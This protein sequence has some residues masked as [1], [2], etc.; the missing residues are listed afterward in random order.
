M[1]AFTRWFR[2]LGTRFADT[3]DIP[4]L[5]ALMAVM[6]ISLMVL[7]S[8]GNS[9][10]PLVFAQ[11]V[12][13]AA[14]LGAMFVFAQ[15]PPSKLR[16]WTPWLFAATL[17]LLL[18]VP[19]I[20]TGQSARSWIK[21]GKM[22]IQPSELLKLTVPMMVAWYLH[23]EPLPPGWKTLAVC[24]AIIGIP[25][26]L[27]VIQPAFGTG[28]LVAASGMFVIFLAGL[29]WWRI[30]LLAGLASGVAPLLWFFVL[31]DFQK[32]RI[33]NFLDPERDPQG[34]GWNIL[35]SQ[36]A[37]GSGGLLGKGWGHS[38]QAHLDFLPEHTTDFIFAV[39]SEEFGW[40]GVCTLLALYLFIVG[41]CLWIAANARETYARLLAGALAMTFFVYAM[42]NGGMVSGLL[43]VV[44]VPMPLL[45]YGGTSAVSLLAGFG[46]VMSVYAHRRFMGT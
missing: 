32:A 3:I 35:Q 45:S 44:G 34:T 21:I 15:I 8:A 39:L 29:A 25:S 19:I 23:R 40:I 33:F 36:I 20:G 37:V 11:G 24:A 41:R 27:I 10:L 26:A 17:G 5:V 30:G 6:T 12:R 43:P 4:L 14:G 18:L 46:I 7:H 38:T 22:S 28:V 42:V 2:G 9:S 1:N 16:I 13:F 31:H